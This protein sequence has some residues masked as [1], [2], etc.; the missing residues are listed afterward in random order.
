MMDVKSEAS[1]SLNN[2]QKNI[3]VIPK[4]S[5]LEGVYAR[6]KDTFPKFDSNNHIL[7]RQRNKKN[8]YFKKQ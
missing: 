1:F 4:D 8:E 5:P 7:D 2:N 6:S 3:N